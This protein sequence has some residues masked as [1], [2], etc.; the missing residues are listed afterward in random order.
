MHELSIICCYNR[1]EEYQA[2][3]ESLNAQNVEVCVV[4][5]DN[6]QREYSSCAAAFNAAMQKVDTPYVVFSHQDILFP[7]EGMIRSF[8]ECLKKIHIHDILGVAGRSSENN[9][10]VTNVRHGATAEY[11][12]GNRVEEM[13][14]CD[15]VDECFFGG[16]AECFRKYPFDEHLCNGWHLYAVERSLAARVRGNKAWVCDMPLI[17]KSQGKMDLDYSKQF[18]HI[19]KR[20]SKHMDYMRTTCAYAP[21]RFPKREVAFLKRSLSIALGRY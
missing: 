21:T 8:M 19:S 4:G 16:T 12:G 1:K 14:A 10:V 3:L 15:S 18:Y 6:S 20:Y 5:I 2:F 7:T 11:A 9:L 13:V 17:H